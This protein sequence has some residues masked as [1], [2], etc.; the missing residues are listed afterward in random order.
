MPRFVILDFVR[1]VLAALVAMMHFN[2]F[3]AP[4]KAYLAVDFFFILSG[5]VLS[6]AYERKAG[7]KAFY[8]SYIVDRIARLY[9]LHLLVLLLLVP[10]NLLFHKTSGGQL[11]ENGWSY[12]DGRIYTFL[13]NLFML[14]NVGLNTAGSWNAPAWSISI[15]MFVNVFLGLAL[16][17]IARKRVV[18]PSLLAVVVISYMFIFGEYGNLGVIY[19]RVFGLFNAGLLRGFAGIALGVISYQLWQ[20]LAQNPANLPIARLV[21]AV[22]A[23]ASMLIMLVFTGFTYGDLAIIPLMFLFV[24]STAVLEKLSPIR[25]GRVRSFMIEL[26]ALSYGVYLLHW[27]VLT[28]MRYQLVY[29]WKVPINF[30][31]PIA[32]LSFLAIVIGSAV[33]IHHKFELPMKGLVRKWLA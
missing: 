23:T 10:V 31:S 1:F 16:I 21:A 33:V 7:A 8:K 30:N 4:H 18:W 32:L 28:F 20:L 11:L 26:G 15:E 19:E 25:D 9:P 6:V 14:Q 24:T 13:L 3:A 2:G 27:L 12:Q 5:F 17:A 22:S 29:V